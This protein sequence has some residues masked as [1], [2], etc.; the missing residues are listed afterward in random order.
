[1]APTR[2]VSAAAAVSARSS[3]SAIFRR[4]AAAASTS[5]RRGAIHTIGRSSNAAAASLAG[6]STTHFTATDASTT[7]DVTASAP[8]IAFLSNEGRA[9]GGGATLRP[10][11]RRTAGRRTPRECVS[12][13]RDRFGERASSLLLH[14]D[15]VRLRPRAQDAGDSF[16]EVPDLELGHHRTTVALTPHGVNQKRRGP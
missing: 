8:G 6:S 2:A 5:I 9:I 11:G 13:H 10:A 7:A 4:R 15:S 1:P 16:V 12:P 3:R 14:R